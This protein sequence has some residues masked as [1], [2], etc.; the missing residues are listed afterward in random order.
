MLI[1]NSM[2]FQG[3]HSQ[4]VDATSLT[5][6]RGS[7]LLVVADSQSAR[8]AT[9]L[10]LSGRMKP[11]AGELSW[12]GASR[13][14]EIR[15]HSAL[16]DAPQIN[17]PEAHLKVRDVVSEDLSLVPAPL[18]RR[19][20]SKKWLARHGFEDIASSWIDA[21]DALTRINLLTRL[22][23]ENHDV[24]ALVFD[25]PDRHGIEETSWL[26]TLERFTRTRRNLAV[27][28]VVSRIPDCWDGPVAFIGQTQDMPE[29]ASFT[30]EV[31]QL[32]SALPVHDSAT[33]SE[34]ENTETSRAP[35]AQHPE[36]NT[37]MAELPAADPAEDTSN[38]PSSDEAPAEQGQAPEGETVAA[39]A[40]VA[41]PSQ[42]AELP[43]EPPTTKD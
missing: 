40:R 21:V 29:N 7:L 19:A 32:D 3:R 39:E 6:N 38:E 42:E 5:A 13:L 20:R 33:G 37:E 11:S 2:S 10:M 34:A 15:S 23:L 31:P 17:E 27:I 28:A 1:A 24:D 9:A 16:L 14:K 12:D 4:L 43:L 22:A 36:P 41:L 30:D 26:E 8:T 18:W 35:L 25:S